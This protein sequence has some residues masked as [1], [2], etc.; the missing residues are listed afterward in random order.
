LL[1]WADIQIFEKVPA[2]PA[3]DNFIADLLTMILC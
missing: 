1:S 3:T 2:A